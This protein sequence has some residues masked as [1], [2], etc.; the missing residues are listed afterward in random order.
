MLKKLLVIHKI[1][2]TALQNLHTILIKDI[3]F[4]INLHTVYAFK[5]SLIVIRITMEY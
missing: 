1:L 2:Q 5:M 3:V 4:P